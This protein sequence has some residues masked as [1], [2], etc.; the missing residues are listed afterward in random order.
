RPLGLLL[1][2]GRL[3]PTEDPDDISEHTRDRIQ[4][5]VSNIDL[6]TQLRDL[7]CPREPSTIFDAMENNRQ[8]HEVLADEVYA[9]AVT[10]ATK[11]IS[12][13]TAELEIV[14]D[15]WYEVIKSEHPVAQEPQLKALLALK[16]QEVGES[17]PHRRAAEKRFKEENGFLTR[18]LDNLDTI[19]G[20]LEDLRCP[21]ETST[22]FDAMENNR[23]DH[24]VLA[25]EVYAQAVTAA[26]KQISAITAELEIVRDS[27]YEV[28]KSEHPV[29]QEPQLKAL[30][31]LKLQEV[32]ESIPHRRAA[33]KRFKEENGFLTRTLDNL[34][35]IMGIL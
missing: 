4:N 13:I 18:T 33:E 25:D 28:I 26:T 34:D 32:G 21:R 8:D 29:A 7:R 2:I 16:L 6:V 23:Q 9:Q 31:A 3:V 12:A 15:S 14:R 17:I 24:E 19:M 1:E 20:I 11:Q 5:A 35:T 10:A 22:I 27:W 30:L